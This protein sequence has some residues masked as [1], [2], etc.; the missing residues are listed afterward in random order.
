[1]RRWIAFFGVFALC[2]GLTWLLLMQAII[3][4]GYALWKV[5]GGYGF[6]VKDQDLLSRITTQ[7]Q[8]A[9]DLR[10]TVIE[11]PCATTC[12]EGFVFCRLI[13]VILKTCGLFIFPLDTFPDGRT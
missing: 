6:V 11:L 5:K 7:I 12:A 3:G 1:M 9:G 13:L 4:P 10:V 8:E 2:F